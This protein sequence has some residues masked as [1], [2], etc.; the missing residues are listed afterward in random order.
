MYGW[1]GKIVRVDLNDK[2]VSTTD[3]E[4]Y[5]RD[6]IGGIGIAEKIYW[7]EGHPDKDAFHPDN[8]LIFMTGPLA[9]TA[10]PAAPRWIVCGKS[11]LMYPETFYSGSMSGFFGAELKM[12]GFDGIVITGKAESPVYINIHDEKVEIKDAR[13]LWGITN[14]NVQDALR[15]AEGDTAKQLSIGPGAENGSRIGTIMTDVGGSGSRGFGSVM[16]AKNLKAIAVAGTGKIPVA[17]AAAIQRIRTRIKEMTGPG[18]FNLYGNPIIA[19]GSSVVKKVHCHGCP[20]G[21]WRT[22][23]RSAAGNEDIRK[24]Q[25]PLFYSLWDRKLHKEV[26]EASFI[27]ATMANDHSFCVLEI[28]FLLRWLENCYEQGI[29]TEQ[30]TELP[31]STM[32]S[33]EFLETFFNKITNK[34][35]FGAVL[36]EGVARAAQQVGKASEE[37]AASQRA[38][39]YGPKTFTQSALLYAVEQRPMVTEL[40]EVCEPLTKWALW[41]LSNGEKSYVSTEV[42]RKIGSRFWGSEKAVDFSTYEGKALSAIKIQNREYAKESL[43]LCDFVWPMFDDAGSGDHV[44][45][46]MLESQ[47]LSA[48]TGQEVSEAELDTLGER[49]FN[50]NRAISLREGRK[51]RE[52]DCLPKTQFIERVEPIADVFGMHNPELLLPGAGDEIISRKGKALDKEKFEQLLDEYYELR[53]WDR[54]TGFPKKEKLEELGLG[55][56]KDGLQDKIV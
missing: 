1:A 40:H 4:Q 50:L 15:N 24:C 19:P 3:I 48:V 47:L 27:A 29:L 8:P 41:Y 22:L 37:I 16:G 44:G 46:P 28:V 55:W 43:I 54:D 34:E 5:G 42:L 18:Y 25:T 39:P 9:A 14:G 38:F 2:R 52:D 7:D 56:V 23:H 20:M 51:G 36:A 30:E 45:A 53:G 49:I 12:A 21:C 6:F 13:H 10:A 17:D 32:G 35:G 31:L 26:T 11:P 33:L